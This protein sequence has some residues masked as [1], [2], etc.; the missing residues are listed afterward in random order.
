MVA[1][2]P[3]SGY[4]AIEDERPH[5]A[6]HVLPRR[7]ESEGRATSP[8]EPQRHVGDH[9]GEECAVAEQSH[10]QADAREQ[11]PGLT[12][13]GYGQSGEDRRASKHG[14]DALAEPCRHQSADHAADAIADIGKRRGERGHRAAGAECFR[15]WNETD[16]HGQGAAG[17]HGEH[18]DC[19]EGDMP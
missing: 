3:E 13:R 6:R 5:H 8:V 4:R 14:D 15:N 7:D 2:P 17:S 11:G 19:G 18:G 9:R 10:P 16:N 12:H 1:L